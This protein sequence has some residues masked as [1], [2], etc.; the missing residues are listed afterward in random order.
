MNRRTAIKNTALMFGYAITAGALTETFIACKNEARTVN[1][2][3]K[4]EFLTTNQANTLAELTETILPR[5]TT[6]GAK[7]VG[8]P[9]F[10][11]KVLKNCC[12]KRNKK[13]SL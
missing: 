1:L 13:T 2:P 3:W 11:D 8:V 5:T 9:Q 12:L 10:I 6:P 7:D 4:P